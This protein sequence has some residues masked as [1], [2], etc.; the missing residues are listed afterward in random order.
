MNC[1]C[2]YIKKCKQNKTLDSVTQHPSW[3]SQ[4]HRDRSSQERRRVDFGEESMQGCRV[5]ERKKAGGNYCVNVKGTVFKN[6]VN[7][8]YLA[9]W[10]VQ[11][12]P[13]SLSIPPSATRAYFDEGIRGKLENTF[14]S[15]R[16]SSV[17]INSTLNSKWHLNQVSLGR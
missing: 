10:N 1:I 12:Y 9:R 16:E 17:V 14:R 7:I 13:L 2:W 8:Q 5:V 6:L 3:D 11:I 4:C 15:R